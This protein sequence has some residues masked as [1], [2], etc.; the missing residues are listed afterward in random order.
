LKVAFYRQRASWRFPGSGSPSLETF[1][2]RW[3]EAGI[4]RSF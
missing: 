3:L 2:A 4:S 1:S